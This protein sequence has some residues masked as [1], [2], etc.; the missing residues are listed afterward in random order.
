MFS[1]STTTLHK[2]VYWLQTKKKKPVKKQLKTLLN[3][4]QN[5]DDTPLKLLAEVAARHMQFFVYYVRRSL[6]LSG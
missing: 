3:Q 6:T 4:Y 2:I 5:K 1:Y